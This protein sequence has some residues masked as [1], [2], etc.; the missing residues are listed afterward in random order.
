MTKKEYC[1]THDSIGYYSGF[2][3]FEIKGIEYGINDYMYAVSG[4]WTPK[5]R[6]H[7]LLIKYHNDGSAYVKFHDCKILL[8]ECLR[9]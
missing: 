6:Y 8:K 2:G 1:M 3:G 7:K 4:A 9:M 5:K